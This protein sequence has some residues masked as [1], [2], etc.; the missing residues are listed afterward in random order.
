MEFDIFYNWLN[1]YFDKIKKIIDC[2]K[3]SCEGWAEK[4][5]LNDF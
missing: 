3:I 4:V 1:Q 5:S 2:L